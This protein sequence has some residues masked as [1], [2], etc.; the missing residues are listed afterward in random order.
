MK[1]AILDASRC[2]S[3]ATNLDR[4]IKAVRTHHAY[5]YVH[6]LRVASH[7]VAFAK[8]GGFTEHDTQSLATAGLVH[9]LGKLL[10]PIN[11]L[12]K[13][14][15]LSEEE[16]LLMRTHVSNR[17]DVLEEVFSDMPEVRNVATMHHERWDGSGYPNGLMGTEIDELA[18]LS[19]VVDVYTALTD[20]RSYKPAFSS[21]K[22]I[23]IMDEMSASAFE[24]RIYK[25]FREM[26]GD[27][28]ESYQESPASA[29]GS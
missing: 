8:S 13:P 7:L 27:V 19:A 29:M 10:V 20:K 25:K 28:N 4:T 12:D 9:D 26:V 3:E 22:A 18:V 6:S 2:L 17:V 23:G 1:E 21:V 16:W 11:V 14:G 5:T 24:P 15:P